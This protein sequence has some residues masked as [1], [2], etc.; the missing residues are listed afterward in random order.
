MMLNNKLT[1]LIHSC[2]KFS[3]LWDTHMLLLNKNWQDRNIDTFLV[4]DK[5]ASRSYNGVT[6]FSAGANKELS[7]RIVAILPFIK[8]EYVLITLDDYFL[9]KKI[10]TEKIAKL[11]SAMDKEELDYIRLYPI[12]NSRFRIKGYQSLFFI[13]L[14]GNYQVNLYPGLWRK[15]FL[16]KTIQKSA[17][18]WQYEVSLTK[19]ARSSDAKC[20]MSKGKEFEI[21]DV[22]RKGKLLHKANRYLKK[23]NLYNGPREVISYKAEL[24]INLLTIGKAILPRRFYNFIK[25]IMIKRGHHFYSDIE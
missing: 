20:A 16:E 13:D 21:L 19:V 22:V 1:L 18:A 11:V 17:N 23:R 5:F 10:Q 12:P 3:D 7:D 2:D 24:R 4:T 25:Q 15:T 6:L 9:I 14:K 8:T